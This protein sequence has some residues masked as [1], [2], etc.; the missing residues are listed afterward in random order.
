MAGG[1]PL[2]AEVVQQVVATTDGVPLFVEELTK[3][4]LESGLVTEREG[5]YELTGPLPPLAIPATLHD[6][7]MARLDRLGPAKQ[8]AQLGAVV[9]RE[10]AYEVLQAVAP[11]EE[12]TLQQG[13]AQL[14]DGRTALP[15]GAAAAGPVPVQ[16]C[17]DPGGGLSV[18]AQEHP[19]PVPPADCPGVGGAVS[20]DRETHPELVAHHYTE[21]GLH[22]AGR[23]LLAA[24]GP[25]RYRA[26]G[27]SWK[28][29]PT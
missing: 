1:K 16:A 9:G 24:G 8:V 11:L 2:P 17:P 19:A 25:A 18:A 5:R 20:R 22:G 29:S 10:F 14:V 4:V 7:L 15:A 26:L 3:M 13:L 21:A 27:L 6:S 23:P 28:R 12:A